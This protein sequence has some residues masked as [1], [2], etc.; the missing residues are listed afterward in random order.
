MFDTI[1]GLPMHPLVVHATVVIVPLAALVVAL[2]A[3]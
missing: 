2:A 1:F 3:L